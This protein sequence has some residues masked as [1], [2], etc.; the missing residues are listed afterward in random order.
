MLNQWCTSHGGVCLTALSMYFACLLHTPHLAASCIP[1][2]LL[3][4]AR[5]LPCCLVLAPQGFLDGVGAELQASEPHELEEGEMKERVH[6]A[7]TR[8]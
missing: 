7:L 3:P 8:K 1:L 2:T 4:H 6:Q 5:P